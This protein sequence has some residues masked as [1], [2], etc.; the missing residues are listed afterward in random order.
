[1]PLGRVLGVEGESDGEMLSALMLKSKEVLI[2][3]YLTLV[4]W[5]REMEAFKEKAV[6]LESTLCELGEKMDALKRELEAES[7]CEVMSNGSREVKDHGPTTRTREEAGCEPGVEADGF[8]GSV[9]GK[10]SPTK[11]SRLNS[12]SSEGLPG[13]TS[14]AQ[15]AGEPSDSHSIAQGES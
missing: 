8:P 1:M 7:F 12:V 9:D 13:S 2:A 10:Q 11:R 6:F 14:E 5:F 15:L 3:D 4:K